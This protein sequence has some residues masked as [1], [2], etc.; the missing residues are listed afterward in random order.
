MRNK[1]EFKEHSVTTVDES[2]KTAIMIGSALLII[3]MIVISIN[4]PHSKQMD[5][6]YKDFRSA[7]GCSVE[8]DKLCRDIIKAVSDNDIKS[9]E[10]V[11]VTD[12]KACTLKVIDTDNTEY[13]VKLNASNVIYE[14]TKDNKVVYSV[15]L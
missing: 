8:Q 1:K 5:K 12:A 14:V 9:I 11:D 10:I 6:T 7:V 2:A 4:Y 15:D 13:I 3:V